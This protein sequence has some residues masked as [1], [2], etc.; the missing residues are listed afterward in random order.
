MAV[1]GRHSS[2]PI[3]SKN[4]KEKEMTKVTKMKGEQKK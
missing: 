2:L 1:M 3:I 4:I